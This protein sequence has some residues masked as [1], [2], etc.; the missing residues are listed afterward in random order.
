MES[1]SRSYERNTRGWSAFDWKAILFQFLAHMSQ[2]VF[3][4]G[5]TSA[6]HCLS[7]ALSS[8]TR[9]YYQDTAT[10]T[11]SISVAILQV[12]FVLSV[13]IRY[14][15]NIVFGL[16]PERDYV[17]VTFGSLLSQIRLSSVCNVRAA[18]SGDWT[19]RQYFFVTAYL[20]HPLTSVQNF[21]EIVPG[22]PSVGGV[23]YKRG[24]NIE[25]WWTYKSLYLING[26]RYGLGY[27]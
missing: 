18:Y 2:S 5:S 14:N 21:T 7:I 9:K 20:S 17:Y 24:S 22:N 12:Q 27:N 26:T 11:K 10:V 19:F 6:M 8:T 4:E 13:F 23:K 25:W 1:K 16:L 3:L 15:T